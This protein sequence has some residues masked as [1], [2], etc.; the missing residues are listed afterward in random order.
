MTT[1]KETWKDWLGPDEPEPDQLF[2]RQEIADRANTLIGSMGKH[3]RAGDL[4]LWEQLGILPRGIRRGHQGAA[5][6]LYPDWTA[7]LVQQIRLLQNQ[8]YSLEEIKPRIRAHARLVLGY[9]R[10]PIDKETWRTWFPDAEPTLSIGRLVDFT[11][12]MGIEPIDQSTLRFWQKD[13][14]LPHPT[15]QK[16]GTGMHAVYPSVA[17]V[18]IE[19]IR[20]LQKAGLTLKEIKPL[21]R[22]MAAAWNDPD[23][24]SIRDTLIEA[25]KRQADLGGVPIVLIQVTFV[26][27]VGTNTSYQYHP[28]KM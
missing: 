23:P 2:T 24:L 27:D 13:G 14:I 17:L 3:V 10:T 11:H 5:R 12:D 25:A 6:N 22:G 19:R 28:D 9:G 26:D 1:V 15:R 18:F 4:R 21:I 16:V 20:N 7:D 8:G